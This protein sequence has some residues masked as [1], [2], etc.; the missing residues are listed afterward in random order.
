MS[1][2]LR[3]LLGPL[4]WAFAFAAIYAL[5]GL[6][7]ALGWTALPAPVWDLH[8]FVLLSGWLLSL[9]IGLLIV[10]AMPDDKSTAGA[11]A[12]AGAWIGLVS[13]LLTLFPVLN[14]SSCEVTAPAEN[15]FAMP[16]P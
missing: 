6:G 13:V 14:L 10:R 3:A 8:R 2:P 4:W 5:H 16:P 7:C 12:R 11:I 9:A 1:W 15:L